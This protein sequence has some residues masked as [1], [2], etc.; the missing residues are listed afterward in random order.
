MIDLGRFVRRKSKE[1]NTT[2][3][4]WSEMIG[5]IARKEKSDRKRR[6]ERRQEYEKLETEFEDNS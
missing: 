3:I 6:H 4:G 1:R 5:L 2:P